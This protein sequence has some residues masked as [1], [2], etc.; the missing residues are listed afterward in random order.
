MGQSGGDF[1]YKHYNDDGKVLWLIE[2]SK[3]TFN[4]KLE[5]TIEKP[6]LVI[7]QPTG[8]ALLTSAKATYDTSAKFCSLSG[9]VTVDNFS[10]AYFRGD[11]LKVLLDNNSLSFS[12]PFEA[13]R[14]PL[15]LKA[16]KGKFFAED[17]RF[18][19]EG[20]TQVEYL[21]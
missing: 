19:T 7:V 15:S 9:N 12:A 20:K 2:G 5:V 13:R 14:G 6:R 10:N 8:N 16:R 1:Q 3:P 4:E 11:H 18:E 17:Q 21:P